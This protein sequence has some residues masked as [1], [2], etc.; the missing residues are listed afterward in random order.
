MAKNLKKIIVLIKKPL[1]LYL[2]ATWP[3]LEDIGLTPKVIRDE[4]GLKLGAGKKCNL[5]EIIWK[6]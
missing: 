3:E 1:E 4:H 5:K 2:G 6:K